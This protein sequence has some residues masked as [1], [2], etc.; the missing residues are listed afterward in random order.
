MTARLV[1]YINKRVLVTE[2]DGRMT[3]GRLRAVDMFTN[4][5]LD[6][7]ELLQFSDDQPPLALPAGSTAIRGDSVAAIALVDVQAEAEIDRE[8]LRCP[9]FHA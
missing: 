5:V 9:P 8:S 7:A 3:C 6:G 1:E 2:V 4:L